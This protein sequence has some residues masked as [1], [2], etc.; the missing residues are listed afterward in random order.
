M[1]SNTD[2]IL[3]LRSSC[4]RCRF[5]KLKC[6]P[7]PRRLSIGEDTC[8]RCF[9]AKVPCIFSRRAQTRQSNDTRKTSREKSQPSAD[10]SQPSPPASSSDRVSPDKSYLKYAKTLGDGATDLPMLDMDLN[11]MECWEPA[12]ALDNFPIGTTTVGIGNLEGRSPVY[13]Y[14]IMREYD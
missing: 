12:I 10:S 13:S 3:S 14:D 8:Q 9:R 4:N 7:A 2:S 6:T 11:Q 1:P 5:Q